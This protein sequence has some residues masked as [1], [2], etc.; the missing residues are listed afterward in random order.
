MANP[1]DPFADAKANIRETVKWLAATFAALAAVVI[2]GSPVSGLGELSVNGLAFWLGALCLL[3]AFTLICIALRVT[4]RILRPEAIFRS[5][6]Y[7]D[8]PPHTNASDKDEL[9]RIRA[10]ING[11]AKDLLPYNYCTL[12]DLGSEL[13][14]QAQVLAQENPQSAALQRARGMVAKFHKE[15]EFLLIF[16]QYLRLEMRLH[17]A[18]PKLLALGIGALVSLTAFGAVVKSGPKTSDKHPASIIV[19]KS[20]SAASEE[21]P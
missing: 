5:N 17:D 4:L 15:F 9:K 14:T 13:D 2:G 6:L 16:A 11:H 7:T 20:P 10:M 8:A 3:S 21:R 12:E 18:L 19:Q 1:H